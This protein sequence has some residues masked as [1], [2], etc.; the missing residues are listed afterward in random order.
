MPKRQNER[1]T[2]EPEG[3]ALVRT[4]NTRTS[5]QHIQNVRITSNGIISTN[6]VGVIT[7]TIDF[8]PS[9]ATEWA[10]FTSIYDEFRVRA[11]RLSLVPYQQGS[12]TAL[13]G[14]VVVAFDNDDNSVLTSLDAATVYE[15]ARIMSG[16]W[17]S[18]Q[19]NI[20]QLTFARPTAGD[21]TSEIW[22]DCGAPATAV[23]AVK[24]YSSAMS[25][26]LQYFTYVMEYFIQFRDRR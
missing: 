7:K 17:Y 6:A 23:G 20:K 3:Y 19:G 18:N 9:A 11:V 15:S 24:M 10:N 1:K 4:F 2:R 5:A 22:Y 21:H 13:N 16:V 25:T 12:V 14:T 26:S 8:N